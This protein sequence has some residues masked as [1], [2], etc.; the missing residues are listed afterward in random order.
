[1]PQRHIASGLAQTASHAFI[2]ERLDA[3]IE[4]VGVTRIAYRE[5]LGHLRGKVPPHRYDGA[6]LQSA[7]LMLQL[8]TA[9]GCTDRNTSDA[10]RRRRRQVGD[11]ISDHPENVMRF[12]NPSRFAVSC[13]FFTRLPPAIATCIGRRFAT[14]RPATRSNSGTPLSRKLCAASKR[15]NDSSLIPCC[16]RMVS[17]WR[18]R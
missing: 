8:P 13:H 3:L 2:D 6:S 17:R 9:P 1:M 7:V 16:R 15:T 11:H 18:A 5:N 4:T 10:R 14:S 12:A